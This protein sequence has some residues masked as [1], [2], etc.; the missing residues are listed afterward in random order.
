MTLSSTM[1][2]C[3]FDFRY[4][5][6]LSSKLQFFFH[7]YTMWMDRSKIGFNC[8]KHAI[9]HKCKKILIATKEENNSNC[10]F[11]LY[12]NLHA[13]SEI[14]DLWIYI[15]ESWLAP[16]IRHAIHFL[17]FNALNYVLIYFY[18][19]FSHFRIWFVRSL[20]SVARSING[21]SGPFILVNYNFF[22]FYCIHA[23]EWFIVCKSVQ[24]ILMR[25]AYCLLPDGWPYC[26]LFVNK[27]VQLLVAAAAYGFRLIH[28]V[29]SYY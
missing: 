8:D 27:S 7:F 12:T 15:F 20:V 9:S 16:D 24:F 5:W 4:N 22:F 19:S 21:A 2:G 3:D 13:W 14:M 1:C 17:S 11:F 18:L 28:L 23:S 29:H 6:I 26:C 10:F 25:A